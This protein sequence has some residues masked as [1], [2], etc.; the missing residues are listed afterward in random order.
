MS[1]GRALVRMLAFP[2]R[3]R[4]HGSAVTDEVSSLFQDGRAS[5]RPIT[6]RDYAAT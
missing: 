5:P 3:G 4:C 6:S 1:K 2:L